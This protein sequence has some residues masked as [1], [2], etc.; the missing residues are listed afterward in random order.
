[1]RKIERE[2]L[3]AA[4]ALRPFKKGNTAVSVDGIAA[5]VYLHG[6]HIADVTGHGSFTF[7][8]CQT[9][10][11]WPTRTTASRL[12]ALGVNASIRNGV[13]MIDGKEA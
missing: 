11:R 5:R 1:M 8:D 13:A 7:V 10:R 6:N 3:A 12:R 2:M 4:H 9:F